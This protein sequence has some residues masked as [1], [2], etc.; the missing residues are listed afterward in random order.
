MMNDSDNQLDLLGSDSAELEQA[1]ATLA[2]LDEDERAEFM[3]RWP[4]NLQSLCEVLRSALISREVPEADNLAEQLATLIGNY[5]GGRDMYIPSGDRLKIALR[6][7]RIWREFKGNNLE[8][9]S[10]HYGLSERRISKIVE[11]QRRAFVA[12]RQRGLF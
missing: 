9:L 12:R 1:L 11:D 5:M 4:A 6:D 3:H 2:S 8:A 10:R 7:I